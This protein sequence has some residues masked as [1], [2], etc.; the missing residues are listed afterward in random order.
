MTPTREL[1]IQIHRECKKFCKPLNLRAV[2]VY[3][4]TGISEQVG[5]IL[6]YLHRVSPLL[7]SSGLIVSGT[8]EGGSL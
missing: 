7:T 1:A 2:C 6:I 3:G 5:V 4:G 8:V